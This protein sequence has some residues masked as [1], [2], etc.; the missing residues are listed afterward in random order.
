MA[1]D[2]HIHSLKGL[3]ED[4][5]RCFNRNVMGSK[6]FAWGGSVNRCVSTGKDTW[7]CDHHKRV[8]DSESVWVGAVSWLKAALFED[9]A[10]FIPEPVQKISEIIG[11]DLPVLDDELAGKIAG[12]L[13]A[14]RATALSYS[15]PVSDDVQE[16]LAAHCGE[17]LF[18]VSW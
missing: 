9:D 10:S 16:W 11:E 3:S 8:T 14:P 13:D 6:Y 2:L 15:T 18:T 12:A 17:R 7:E 4:D 5:I 1:A